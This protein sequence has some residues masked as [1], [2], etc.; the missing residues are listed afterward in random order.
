MIL[1]ATEKSKSLTSETSQHSEII[2]R[3]KVKKD[4]N[5]EMYKVQKEV[6]VWLEDQYIMFV[7][8]CVF[9]FWKVLQIF[10]SE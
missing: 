4:S 9:F 6:P 5:M 2:E 1:Q 10:W 8:K 7:I 3:E